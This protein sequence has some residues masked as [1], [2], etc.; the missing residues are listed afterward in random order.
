ADFFCERSPATPR[1]PS[2]GSCLQRSR[3][4]CPRLVLPYRSPTSFPEFRAMHRRASAF[5][6]VLGLI[7]LVA[8]PVVWRL[9]AAPPVV[10][11]PALTA[12]PLFASSST[13]E[14]TADLHVALLRAGISPQSLAAIGAPTGG[15]P[16]LVAAAEQH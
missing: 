4:L 5:L 11:S 12:S 9:A 7:T 8:V 14:G 16:G 6:P 2:L 3:S 10:A 15:I 13:S 1:P